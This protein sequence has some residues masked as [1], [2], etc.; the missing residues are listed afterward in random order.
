MLVSRAKLKKKRNLKFHTCI[1]FFVFRC[2]WFYYVVYPS[3]F[4]GLPLKELY[5]EENPLLHHVPVH[6]VQEEEVLSLKVREIS[7][8]NLFFFTTTTNIIVSLFSSS[9]IW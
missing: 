9:N 1:F 7:I 4:A 2:T 6:S 8:L 5:C 3:Q